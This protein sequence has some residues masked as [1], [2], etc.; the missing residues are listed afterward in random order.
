[1]SDT[2]VHDLMTIGNGQLARR[3]QGLRLAELGSL[4]AW[5]RREVEIRQATNELAALDDRQ[6]ADIGVSRGRIDFM[7][8]YGRETAPSETAPSQ[9]QPSTYLPVSAISRP[10]GMA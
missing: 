9:T 10:G 5:F 2:H 6:L 3:W 4:I 8:R 7:A 1:M